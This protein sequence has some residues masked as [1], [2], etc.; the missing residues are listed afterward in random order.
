MEAR[1]AT[2][3]NNPEERLLLDGHFYYSGEI[4]CVSSFAEL[5]QAFVNKRTPSAAV[6]AW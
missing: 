6:V 2:V 1:G 3:V 5:S 4:P